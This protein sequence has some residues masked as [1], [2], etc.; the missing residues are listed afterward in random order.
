MPKYKVA[1]AKAYFPKGTWP[2]DKICEFVDVVEID[3]TSRTEAAKEAWEIKSDEWLNKMNPRQTTRRVV[4]LHV[5]D[6]KAG[7]GGHAE[8]LRPIRVY[9]GKR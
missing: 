3:A 5:N 8:R 9:E 1:I 6:P 2:E 7:V 4:S